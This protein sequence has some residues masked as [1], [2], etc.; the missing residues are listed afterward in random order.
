MKSTLTIGIYKLFVCRRFSSTKNKNKYHFCRRFSSAII[1]YK[2]DTFIPPRLFIVIMVKF[3]FFI[4]DITY[5]VLDTVPTVFLFGRSDSG[6]LCCVLFDFKPFFYAL[7]DGSAKNVES[8]S[9]QN[10]KVSSVE[11][12]NRL[13]FEKPIMALK[14]F[15]SEPSGVPEISKSVHDIG[16]RTFEFDIPFVRRF[17]FEKGITP[18]TK[19]LVNAYS[20]PF[21]SRVPV[22]KA[23]SV[24]QSSDDVVPLKVLSIDIESYGGPGTPVDFDENPI[25]MIAVKGDNFEKV[26][27]WKHFDPVPEF[28][29]IVDGESSMIER[30]YHIIEDY[31]PDIITGYHS[32]GFDIPYIVR[33]AKKYK[34]AFD[35][36]LDHSDI[37]LS[38]GAQPH[39][40]IIGIIHVDM[41]R[42]AKRLLGRSL[43]TDSYKLDDVAQELLGEKKISVELKDLSKAWD[44]SSSSLAVFAEYNLHDAKLVYNLFSK[45]SPMLVELV[46]IVGLPLFDISR[47]SFSQL[48]EWFLIKNAVLRGEIAPN[49]PSFHEEQIRSEKR[50]VG[51][52]VFEPTP[53]VYKNVCVFDYRSLYPS[54]IASHN[55]SI[56]SLQCDCCA[57]NV[58]GLNFHFCQKKKGF[59]SAI[60][61]DVIARR[62]RVKVM[63]KTDKSDPL[64]RARSEVLKVLAN[65]HV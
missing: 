56:G 47:M 4:T 59:I 50:F 21:T 30:V 8:V 48:V 38:K 24:E 55:I 40:K 39:A 65:F 52:F 22:F 45:V 28:V 60:I 9:V 58:P 63:L 27:T 13:L 29:E 5:R 53:G 35:I 46:K 23:R 42:V 26:I 51:A 15:V 2:T 64:L 20:I 25:L 41:L 3:G 36:G 33:R 1:Q 37:T 10:F 61:E 16:F 18:L 19:V 7:G 11:Q 17:L 31:K 12:V 43:Q 57:V 62:A 54:V 6:E 44:D 49:K 14:V 34:I 32:D